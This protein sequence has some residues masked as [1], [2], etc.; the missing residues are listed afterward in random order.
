MKSNLDFYIK[1][2]EN[3]SEGLFLINSERKI[4]FVNQRCT[5][6]TGWSIDDILQNQNDFLDYFKFDNGS[7]LEHSIK[8]RKRN[9]EEI[10]L[11]YSYVRQGDDNKMILVNLEP[12]EQKELEPWTGSVYK[13]LYYNLTDPVVSYDIKGKVINVNPSAMKLLGFKRKELKTASALY[14]EKDAFMFR[15]R[16]LVITKSQLDQDVQLKTKKGEVRNFHETI[17]PHFDN[18]FEL[19]GFTAHYQ[20]LSKEQLLRAQLSASQANYDRLFEQFASSIVI[21]DEVGNVVN[22]NRAAEG[23]YGWSREEM[24]GVPYD[25]YFSA[26]KDR[27]GIMEIIKTTKERGGKHIDIGVSR[28]NRNGDMLFVYVTYYLIDLNGKGMFA[29]FVLEKDLT[30]RIK[31]E[32]K[33]EESVYQVKETQAAA[34]MGFAKL[35]EF[36]DH[37]TGEHLERIKGYTRILAEEMKQMPE[38]SNYITDEY[39]EDISMSSILHDIGKVGI[40]DSI[41]LK[42][43][44]LSAEEFEIMK[45]HANMG[46]DAL[47]VIDKNVGY[48]SFLTI[49]KE[50]ASYHHEK[51]DG[52]GYP[53]GLK[54][55]NIPL[56][57]RIVALADVYDALIS[58][59]PYKQAFTHEDAVDT[60]VKERSKHF[61]PDVVDAFISCSEAFFAISNTKSST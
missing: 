22:M 16:E 47:T 5:E 61:D 10:Y 45:H 57:A 42:S 49:G 27:P 3:S 31:L 48:K 56:S 15:V 33:L 46:G 32:K 34:I 13:H 35:T 30:T 14:T 40:E 51:W 20:D 50:I 28:K 59:R 11:K 23:L 38:Y 44:K 26:G 18:K 43:G 29:L 52:S 8:F 54:G 41:L 39:I 24:L 1:I 37:C 17:W 58:E 60:I 19:S 55:N 7:S 9:H 12:F 2:F 4:K 6:L 25:E 21:V 36:R 53:E